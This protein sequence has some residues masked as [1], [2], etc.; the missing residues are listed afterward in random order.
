MERLVICSLHID[1]WTSAILIYARA[2]RYTAAFGFDVV[3]VVELPPS[4]FDSH[5]HPVYLGALASARSAEPAV[6]IEATPHLQT[7]RAL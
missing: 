3:E 4:H 7:P 5:S 6:E 2:P 1:V